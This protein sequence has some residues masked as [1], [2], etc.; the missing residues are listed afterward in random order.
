MKKITIMIL[1]AV[2]LVDCAYADHNWSGVYAGVN[3]GVAFNS[4]QLHSQQIGFTNLNNTCDAS[5]DFSTFGSG[6]QFGYL[7]QFANLIAVGVEGNFN[8]NANQIT[9]LSCVSQFNA[10][11]YDRFLL[12]TQMQTAVK[13]RVGRVVSW[14]QY[15]LFPYLT[16][17]ASFANIDLTYLNE[18][19][20]YYSQKAIHP[21]WLLGAG[22][23]WEFRQHWS[24]RAE[25]DY[26]DYGN[27]INVNLPSVYNLQDAN[28]NGHVNLNTSSLSA[29][30]SYWL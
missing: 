4:A 22:V 21:G 25:Y 7:H 20:D 2:G 9:A 24:L 17:G 1:L 23:E 27:A 29:A 12:R 13:A 3:A 6:V 26:V 19:G 16:T 30:L 5:A 15:H 18:G 10:N 14:Q 8:L 11:V 28:G